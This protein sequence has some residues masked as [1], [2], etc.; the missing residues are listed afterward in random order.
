[1]VSGPNVLKKTVSEYPISAVDI[2]PTILDLAGLSV[3]ND[4]DGSTFV[5]EL[6]F[7]NLGN[8]SRKILIEYRGEGKTE[9]VDP[10]C[11]SP[12]ESRQLAVSRV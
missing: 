6:F 1:M 5:Q 8:L 7:Q 2:A 10:G 3:P 4:M 12:K 11:F 9:T